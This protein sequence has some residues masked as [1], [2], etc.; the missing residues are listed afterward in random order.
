M[1][2]AKLKASAFAMSYLSN[3][4]RA[5][6]AVTKLMVAP[7][8]NLSFISPMG[9]KLCA[10]RLE[11]KPYRKLG[12]FAADMNRY[13]AEAV[14]AG[15]QLVAFPELTGMLA[16]TLMPGFSSVLGDLR[17]LERDWENLS[18]AFRMTL[19]AVHGFVGEPYLNTFSQLAQAHRVVI[20][21]GSAYT[22]ESGRIHHRHYLFSENGELAG[23]QVKL[24]PSPAERRLGVTEGERL[25]P[26]ETKLG[27]VA[28]LG[29]WETAQF[30]PF[31]VAAAMGCPIAVAGAS[32]AG[33]DP[34]LAR[35]RA[36]E[37]RMAVICPGLSGGGAFGWDFQFEPAIY[38]PLAATRTRDGVVAAADVDTLTARVDLGKITGQFD[39]YSADK[40]FEFIKNS[41]LEP[42]GVSD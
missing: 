12:D 36:Q 14:S 28:L 22:I 41:F 32:P 17:N 10:V 40:N 34:P 29:G 27:R 26:A 38:A 37:A 7:S 25:T 2:K 11:A 5:R 18:E 9:V 1:L 39:I 35:Y 8:K 4:E 24:F 6:G 21:A 42:V 15:A 30:E 3:A 13:V 31:Y 20:A 16:M 33:G 23:T 19:E